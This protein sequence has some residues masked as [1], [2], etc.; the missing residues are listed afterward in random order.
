MPMTFPDGSWWVEL[1]ARG[2]SAGDDSSPER[3]AVKRETLKADL[4]RLERRISK[5][6]EEI[7]EATDTKALHVALKAAETQHEE[8]LARLRQLDTAQ[9]VVADWTTAGHRERVEG[10]LNDWQ[11][12]LDGEPVLGRQVLRKLLVMSILV[13]PAAD[14]GVVWATAGTFGHI[15]GQIGGEEPAV[16]TRLQAGATPADLSAELKALVEAVGQSEATGGP[17]S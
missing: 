7:V 4:A 6:V 8:L 13:R 11:A 1:L 12:A 9:A 10:I 3:V 15:I 14:G 5:L 17:T 2:L 16:A